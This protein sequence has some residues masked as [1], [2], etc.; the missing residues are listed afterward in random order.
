MFKNFYNMFDIKTS[1]LNPDLCEHNSDYHYIRNSPKYIR[2]KNSEF[3]ENSVN[4]LVYHLF[5]LC[6]EIN[7]SNAPNI[8][9][10]NNKC[11]LFHYEYYV[12]FCTHGDIIRD[13]N[14]VLVGFLATDDVS[15]SFM[16][17]TNEFE[18]NLK[19]GDFIFA[20]DNESIVPMISSIYIQ[21]NLDK[22]SKKLKVVYANINDG[23]V[24]KKL[25]CKKIIVN[26]K[27]CF[28][29][30]TYAKEQHETF[31]E[32]IMIDGIVVDL[33]WVDQHI[34]TIIIPNMSN[35]WENKK[36]KICERVDVYKQELKSKVGTRTLKLMAKNFGQVP[37]VFG[38]NLITIF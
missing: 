18:Y 3:R 33:K 27:H 26:N 16:F 22:K 8:S 10:H 35:M 21:M 29:Y 19:K 31:E 7:D 20:L 1:K 23:D 36:K 37:M 9:V 6:S 13:K 25:E 17:S 24:I 30:G 34:D 15:F 32:N 5:E 38:G 11:T 12:N 14:H 4:F 2:Q 28:H